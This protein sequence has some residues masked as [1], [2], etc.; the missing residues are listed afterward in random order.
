MDTLSFC[1]H[2]ST[3]KKRPIGRSLNSLLAEMSAA[4]LATENCSWLA[5]ETN[6]A[7]PVQRRSRS[8]AAGT[9]RGRLATFDYSR[10]HPSRH[11]CSTLNTV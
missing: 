5:N 4:V 8:G 9:T 2:S 7:A 3:L 6:K 10:S 1:S 11:R